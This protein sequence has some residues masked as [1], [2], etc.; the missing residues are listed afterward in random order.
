M[1]FLARPDPKIPGIRELILSLNLLFALDWAQ[2]W[3]IE[4]KQKENNPK[5]PP[6][7]IPRIPKKV[8]FW[9]HEAKSLIYSQFV[10]NWD[11]RWS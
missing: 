7:S 1:E 5:N 4:F 2:I 11:V 6:K 9:D 8:N 10:E 3:V